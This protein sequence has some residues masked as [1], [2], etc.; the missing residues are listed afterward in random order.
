MNSL[1]IFNIFSNGKKI[2]KIYQEGGYYC[3]FVLFFQDIDKLSDCKISTMKRLMKIKV[4]SSS[5]HQI[6]VWGQPFV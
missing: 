2:K 6:Q 4:T 5:A 3:N 1:V